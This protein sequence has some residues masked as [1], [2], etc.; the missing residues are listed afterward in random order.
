MASLIRAY[1]FYINYCRFLTGQDYQEKGT[2]QRFG[3]L[4]Q[5]ICDHTA[6]HLL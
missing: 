2:A 1:K 4:V 5:E 6:A 3:E